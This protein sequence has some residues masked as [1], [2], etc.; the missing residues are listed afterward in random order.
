MTLLLC[1]SF[2]CTASAAD[3]EKPPDKKEKPTISVQED[4]G[5]AIRREAALVKEDLAQR[6]RSLFK[7]EPL[8]WDGATFHYIYRELIEIP[9]EIPALTKLIL[10]HSRLLGFLGS[11]LVLIFISAVLYGLLGHKRVMQWVEGKA[12]PL[13][14]SLPQKYYPIFMSFLTVVT[15]IL[16]PLFLLGLYKLLYAMITY[17]A[18]WFHLIGR[19]LELWTVGAL[20]LSALREA[21]T[22]NYLPVTTTQGLS[23]FRWASAISLYALIAIATFWTVKAFQVRTDVLALFKFIIYLIVLI[24]TFFLF[25]K[26]NAFIS[27][28]P[29][30]PYSSYLIIVG[31]LKKYYH[32]LLCVSFLAALLWLLGYSA[33]GSAVLSKIWF[34]IS[35]FLVVSLVYHMLNELVN[36]CS[37]HLDIKN[38]SALSLARSIR[39]ALL[40]ATILATIL[41]TL[42][43]LG[44]LSV[45]QRLISFPI[46][47]LRDT[48]VTLWIIL[49]AIIILLGFFFVSRLLQ[50]YFEYKVYP[51][52]G[53]DPGLGYA[54][55]MFFKYILLAIGFVVSLNIVGLDLK[56]LLVFAGAL[57]IG[58]GFGLQ[59]IAAN[60]ISGFTIIF[61]GK[62]R[63]GDW[64]EVSGKLGA[65]TGIYLR[66]TNVRTRDNIE[67]LIPNAELISTT[68]VNYSLSSALIRMAVPVGVSYNADP[69]QVARILLD[70]AEKEPLVEKYR[71]PVVRFVEYGDSSINF[72]LLIWIDVRKVPR[73]NVKSALY[74]AIFEQFK[75]A[76]I[77][78]PFPQRDVHIK[79]GAVR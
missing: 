11:L 48:Q 17:D 43:T 74:F 6:T 10:E 49:K 4:V 53:I 26:K 57:G 20:I 15:H 77:E 39:S 72:E 24:S 3:I 60:I 30:R 50:D 41:I 75:K 55:N 44:L 18:V 47:Q 34:T 5:E 27:F 37:Q 79:S 9:Q 66:A 29:V 67:Y 65:V 7:R 62:I 19:L 51:S 42:N 32:T 76:G 70:V 22:R 64:I 58:I 78:I 12:R 1:F 36:K 56:F 52:L 33:L 63:R 69:Q 35:A 8:G 25:L 16:I 23:L 28:F 13:V 40:F 46:L 59:N 38:E 45:T 61:G 2:A 73:R 68:I 31:I 71:A 54:L 21:L 14:E